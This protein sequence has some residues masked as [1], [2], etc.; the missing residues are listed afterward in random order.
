MRKLVGKW[1]QSSGEKIW[2]VMGTEAT[3]VGPVGA[4]YKARCSPEVTHPE[5]TTTERLHG[6]RG[7]CSLPRRGGGRRRREAVRG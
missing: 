6:G 2:V 3:G 5:D 1:V 4:K 7:G